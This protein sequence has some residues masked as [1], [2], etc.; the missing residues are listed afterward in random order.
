MVRPI[1]AKAI[2]CLMAVVLYLSPIAFEFD[3]IAQAAPIVDPHAPVVFQ[4][5]ITQS[6]TGVPVVNIAAPNSNGLSVNSFSSFN[7]DSTGLVLNNSLFSGTPLAGGT[8]NANPNLAGRTASVILNQVTS[9]GQAST[10]LGPLEVFGNPATVIISNPNGISVNGLALTNTTGLVLTTGTPQF[11]TGVGGTSTSFNNAASVAYNVSSGNITIDGPAGVNGPGAGIQGTSGSL[12]LIAQTINLNAPVSATGQVNLITG[13]QLVTPMATGTNGSTYGVSAN[14]ATNTAAAIGNGAVAIDASQYGSV[15]SGQIFIVST[16]AGMGVNHAGPLVATAGNVVVTSNGDVTVGQTAAN[17]NVILTSAGNTTITDVG[18][19]NQNYTV[20]AAGDINA[21]G[22]I[23]AV[24]NATLT[25]GGNLNA[26]S[27]ATN[28]AATLGAGGSMTVGSVAGLNTSLQTT[29]GDLTVN[30]ALSAAGTLNASAGQDLVVNGAVQGGSTVTLAGGRNATVNGVLTGVGT[31]TLTAQSGNA[32]VSGSLESN[33][34]VSVTAGQNATLADVQAQGPVSITAQTGTLSGGAVASSQDAVTLNAGQNI[35][36]SG[37]LQSATTVGATAGGSASFG[38]VAAPG[39]ITLQSAQDTTVGGDLTGGSTVTV[40]AGGNAT[41]Q[42]STASVGN[43][44]LSA[45]GGMLSSTGSLTTNGSLSASGQQGVNLAGTTFSGGNATLSSSAGNVAVAALSSPGTIAITAGQD[46]NASGLVHSGLDTTLTA[47]RDVNL[48]GGLEVDGTANAAVNAGRDIS[49]TTINVANNTTLS[50][51]RNLSLSSALQTGNN[52]SATATQNLNVAAI[53]AVGTGTLTATNGSA[54]LTGAALTGSD[55]TVTAGTNINAQGSVESLGNLNLNAQSGNLTAGGT[56]ASAGTGTLNAGQTLALN[57]QTTVSGN[58]VLTGNAITTQGLAVGGNLTATAQTTLDTSAGQLNAAYTSTAPALSVGGNAT[59][60]GANVTTANAVIGGT[61]SATGTTSLTTGGTAAYQGNATLTGGTV[62]NVGQQMAAGNLTV[63]GTTVT[64]QSSGALSALQT[65]TVDAANVANA[66]S[67]YGPTTN[68]N[69]TG[70]L[71][72]SGGLLA[73]DTL[74][75]STG[76]LNN[77]AGLIFAGDVN[78]PTA[79]VGNMTV[80]AT[81][82]GFSNTNGQILAQNSLTLNLANQILDPSA[83]TTGTLNGGNAYIL[84][85]LGIDNTGTWTLPGTA[86]TVAATQ[87]ITNLGTINQGAGTLTLNG[88]VNNSGGITAQ[89]LTINGSLANQAHASVTANDALTLNGSGT[90]AGTVS[91][92]N[93]LTITGTNYDNSNGITQVGSNATTSGSGNLNI[94]LSGNLGNANG[95]LSAINNLTIAA[96]T[97]NNAASS[98]VTTSTTTTTILNTPLLM[99]TVIGTENINVFVPDPDDNGNIHTSTYDIISPATLGGILSV[100]GNAVTMPNCQSNCA[101]TTAPVATSGTVQYVQVGMIDG[102]NDITGAPQEGAFWVVQDGSVVGAMASQTLTIPTVT[103]TTTTVQ[104]TTGSSVIVAGQNLSIT[105][106]SLNNLGGT[107]SAG[108]DVNLNIQSL[109]NGGASYSSTVTDTVDAASL[110]AFLSA[111][112]TMNVN[113][114][115]S[116]IGSGSLE[117]TPTSFIFDA[118]GTVASPTVTSSLTIQGQTGQIV[119][120]HNLNLSGGTLTNAGTLLAGND[121]NITASN[122]TNLGVN[123]GT[124]TTSTGCAAGYSAGCSGQVTTNPNSQSYSY[125]QTNS[126]ITAGN[127]V[128]IAAPTFQNQYGNV[129]AGRNVVIGGTGTTASDASTTPTSLT[130]ASSVTNTSGSIDAG[131]DVQISAGSVVNTIAAPVLVHQNY[132]SAT[133]YSGCNGG[134]NTGTCEAYVDVQSANP[135][136]ITANHNVTISSASLNNTGSLITALNNVAITASSSATSTNQTLSAYWFGDFNNFG[137]QYSAWGCAG[138]ASTC[139]SLYGSAYVPGQTQ[140]PAGLPS[141]VGLPNFVAATIQA[142]G[143]LSVSSPTLSNTGSVIGTTVA[144]SGSQLINGI[145]NPNVYTPPPVVTH[146]VISL[147]IPGIPSGATTTI[148]SAGLVTTLNGN[149]IAVTGGA[150]LAPNTALGAQTVGKPVAPTVTSAVAPTTSTVQTSSGQSITVSYLTNNPAAAVLGDITPAS[151]LANL[152]AS[153]QPGNVPFYYD[154]YTQ[155]QLVEQAALTATGQSS[156][157]STTTATDSTSQTSIQNQD[158]AALY[159]ASLEYAE[160]N[161]IAVGTQLSAA[162]LALVNEPMLWY[163]QETVPEPGCTATGGATC[164]TVQALMPEVLLPQNYASVSAAGTISGTTVSLNYTNSILNTGSITAQNLTVDTESLTNEERS[165]NVGTIYQQVDG[166]VEVTTGTAVQGGGFMS[167]ANYTLNA[168]TITQIGGTLQQANTDGSENQAGTAQ[169]LA[170]LK[171]Q[172]GSSFTQTTASNH[173]NTTVIANPTDIFGEVIQM[174]TI[175]AIS[176]MSAGAASVG[177]GM[178]AGSAGGGLFS[179]GVAGTAATATAPAVTAVSAGLGNVAL[180][181]AVGGMVSSALTQA[182]NGSF[183]LGEMLEAGGT[184]LLTAGLTNGITVGDGG[185]GWSW[186][187]S[188]DSLASLS[189]VQS[190]GNSLVPQ[191]SAAS[192]SL[193]AEIAAI[194][195]DAAISAGVQTALEG[196]SFLSNLKMAG[197]NDAAADVAFA[198]GNLQPTLTSDLGAVGGEIAYVA[199]HSALGCAA[200]AAEGTGCAGGAIGAASS[201]LI[202]PFIIQGID[203]NGVA[204][205]S[206]QTAV[207]AALSTLTGGLSAGAVGANVQAGGIWGENEGVNNDGNHPETAVRSANSFETALANSWLGQ[208]GTQIASNITNGAVQTGKMVYDSFQSAYAG[209]QGEPASPTSAL[210]QSF[211]QNGV[212]PTLQSLANQFGDDANGALQGDPKSVGNIVTFFASL[213]IP[214]AEGEASTATNNTLRFSQTTASPW[215]SGEGNFAGFTISD[216]A[217]QLRAGTLSPSDLPIQT[218]NVGGDTLIINTRSSLALSEA[219]IPQSQ[220]SLVDMTGDA[221]TEAAIAA[222]LAKNGLT[223]SGTPTLRITGSGQSTST[224]IGGGSIPPPGAKQ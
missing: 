156:F 150:V 121:V 207:L 3:E 141:A 109:S 153:L 9:T 1:W 214:G 113:G 182:G 144:L 213:G 56:V 11:L 219:G 221:V 167:A 17:Q 135:A 176:I 55:L 154:P 186:T 60:S 157:Y 75:L 192:G 195:G 46:V 53:T 86:V 212:L 107:V 132:G 57:G 137:T 173:L 23:S 81:G 26:A 106:N 104:A 196:G 159:G 204:L 143:T 181:A 25:A 211:Q 166:G 158:T 43:L 116:L 47:T 114:A 82:S 41:L 65:V 66:G 224:Y 93:A 68:L 70:T 171:T 188:S 10:L 102:Q 178:A 16:A 118:P 36:L 35:Q 39:A 179:A 85:V 210:G 131:N 61:Y 140:D 34:N 215:F 220:W 8:I 74:A 129:V 88:A 127:D 89:D 125:T 198:I 110:N 99:S 33:G 21:S 152:P 193:P 94:N 165:T 190:V 73:T 119:A 197:V 200:S 164:P 117:T 22:A 161:N 223:N 63:S 168:Q 48:N 83:S 18:Q 133:P 78:N 138:S 37:A 145:T 51:G 42:G 148:N 62:T 199:A 203:P 136:T 175:V 139:Q 67:I 208:V 111:L 96:N 7:I 6:S 163:V 20:N 45:N 2:A 69:V 216:V 184:A 142:G 40:A 79:A 76:Q 90:N 64:N 4:P 185:V 14:G 103:E 59:L 38:S 77:N 19:A 13:N 191:A 29:T 15:T 130:Q 112:Q 134:T 189:G 115:V 124:L 209:L 122:F 146:Q 91:A 206:G 92:L 183:N 12:D 126:T 147:G 169:L 128:V 217:S 123:N 54:T 218:I 187:G 201:A 101:T 108:N 180:S 80:T 49:G 149:L 97:I 44:S 84:N 162:Q 32:Q 222:R 120:G 202:S 24:Q 172:L 174:A 28:G 5:S 98:T 72:N 50:A 58:A 31:V 151:L 177:I 87:G 194:T 52:L 95:T 27:V 205:N 30:S 100:A 71:S 155:A 105:A 160:Q 170:N